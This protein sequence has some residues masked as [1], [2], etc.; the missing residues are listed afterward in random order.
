[1]RQGPLQDQWAHRTLQERVRA[2]R[3]SRRMTNQVVAESRLEGGLIRDQILQK[4][5]LNGIKLHLIFLG[6]KGN[7]EDVRGTVLRLCKGVLSK[8]RLRVGMRGA[9]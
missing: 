9:Q 2:S 1:M 8:I 7:K 6:H 3:K 5:D 4:I